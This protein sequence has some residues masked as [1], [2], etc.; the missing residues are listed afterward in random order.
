MNCTNFL[1]LS[2]YA[3]LYS[4]RVTLREDDSFNGVVETFHIAGGVPASM[5]TG[6]RI[7]R[8]E[9]SVCNHDTNKT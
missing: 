1:L 6:S 5:D 2:Y 8:L 3:V 4:Q 9:D 7:V